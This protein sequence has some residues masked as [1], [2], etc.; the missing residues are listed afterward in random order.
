MIKTASSS[1]V[2]PM[3]E[4]ELEESVLDPTPEEARVES[5]VVLLRSELDLLLEEVRVELEPSFLPSVLR[6]DF[7]LPPLPVVLSETAEF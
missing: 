6:P 1:L 4:T 2:Q 5:D 3:E 7:L